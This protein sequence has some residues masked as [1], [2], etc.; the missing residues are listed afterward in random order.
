[1]REEGRRWVV[2]R[3]VSKAWLVPFASSENVAFK[4]LMETFFVVVCFACF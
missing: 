1:M 4:T 2:T 3:C